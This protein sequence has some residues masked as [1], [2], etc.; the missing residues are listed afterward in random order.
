MFCIRKRFSDSPKADLDQFRN[1]YLEKKK[2]S[3]ERWEALLKKMS[4]NNSKAAHKE[5]VGDLKV[6]EEVVEKD[7]EHAD[8]SGN[9]VRIVLGP[10]V[11]S[12]DAIFMR[13]RGS[14]NKSSI[15]QRND[16]AILA[17]KSETT[18][19]LGFGRVRREGE[20]E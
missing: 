9:E 12:T 20:Q 14:A 18:V 4:E 15:K 10:R 3:D 2:K 19:Y 5:K 1:K 16:E 8:Y 13:S 17:R 7:D 11:A 6:S